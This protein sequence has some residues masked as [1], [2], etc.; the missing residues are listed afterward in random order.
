MWT[1]LLLDNYTF[2]LALLIVRMQCFVEEIRWNSINRNYLE[3]NCQ[4]D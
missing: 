1:C 4:E 3:K 2:I